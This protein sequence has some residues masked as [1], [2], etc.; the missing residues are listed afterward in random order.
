MTQCSLCLQDARPKCASCGHRGE[1]PVVRR[2]TIWKRRPALIRKENIDVCRD[3]E[4]VIWKALTECKEK[5]KH[6]R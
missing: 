3:C 6:A 4:R 5:A 2:I 1:G